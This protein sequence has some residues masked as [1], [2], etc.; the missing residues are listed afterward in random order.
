MAR[1]EAEL[2]L[3]V[4][5]TAWTQEEVTMMADVVK[6][7]LTADQV[8]DDQAANLTA[9]VR[10]MVGLQQLDL[11]G[12][13]LGPE[14]AGQLSDALQDMNSGLEVRGLA[15]E[16][17]NPWQILETPT[18]TTSLSSPEPGSAFEFFQQPPE[19]RD[20]NPNSN[21]HSN[22]H[23]NLHTSPDHHG[24]GAHELRP[25]PNLNPNPNP[26]PVSYTHLTLP[27]KRIV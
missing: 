2:A 16:G 9:A 7:D 13:K 27:T 1:S 8:R 24:E 17:A 21:S 23:S 3:R 6:M 5:T 12:N 20:S 4:P 25:N 15:P 18:L 22:S 10:Q 11:S 19:S 26:T 14:V